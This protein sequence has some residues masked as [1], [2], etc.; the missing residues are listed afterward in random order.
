[1]VVASSGGHSCNFLT[2]A[3]IL[4]EEHATAKYTQTGLQ[5]TSYSYGFVPGW[6]HPCHCHGL[7]RRDLQWNSSAVILVHNIR[8]G[9]CLWN[10]LLES[11]GHLKHPVFYFMLLVDKYASR[12]VSCMA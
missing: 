11:G 1:M 10:H 7:Q 12:R 9:N 2:L 8:S 4:E 5:R 3:A 6:S